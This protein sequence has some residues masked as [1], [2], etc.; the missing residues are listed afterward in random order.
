MT[1]MPAPRLSY[2]AAL[3]VLALAR[4]QP[5]QGG[6][7]TS[8]LSDYVWRGALA[9]RGP[10]SQSSLDVDWRGV[11]FRAWQNID[12]TSGRDL[13]GEISEVDYDL[14]YT[15]PIHKFD[16]IAGA[17]R[18]TFPH[19]GAPPT[20]ELYAG[21]SARGWLNP[22]M[23]AYFGVGSAHGAYLTF[24]AIHRFAFPAKVRPTLEGLDVSVGAGWGSASYHRAWF[25]VARN[26]FS[27]FHP[28]AAVSVRIARSVRLA[29]TL[30]WSMILDP[31]LRQSPWAFHG[32]ILGAT[33]SA[34]LCPAKTLLCER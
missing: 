27:D 34:R 13:R 18:Y 9:A 8:I 30:A 19:A 16:A 28:S 6:L 32:F 22:A 25:A 17:I 23:R 21:A 7:A 1:M 12:L 33:L 11:V 20:T 2:G 31:R 4:A 24:D 26:G 10:V 5:P 14:S 15:A 3:L 29:P